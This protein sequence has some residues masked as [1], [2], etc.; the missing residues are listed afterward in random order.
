MSAHLHFSHGPT[1]GF[2]I[3]SYWENISTWWAAR[4]LPNVYL[5]HFNALKADLPGEM[6][7]LA[8][9]LEIDV[10]PAAWPTILEHCSFDY[11]KAHAE[12]VTP[13]AGAVFKGG[14][15]QFINR[16]VNGRWR[17]VLSEDDKRA[18]EQ[19]AEE[20]LGA[21]CAHWLK[22]GALTGA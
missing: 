4:T 16:G 21:P 17:D 13:L 19:R 15:S 9:F 8:D 12:L 14:A 3:W 6:K 1:D 18:Y 20:K 2:P 22:T 5:T 11:M 10:E 7:K